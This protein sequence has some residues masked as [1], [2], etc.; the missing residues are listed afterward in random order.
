[1][2][3]SLSLPTRRFKNEAEF[4]TRFGQEIKKLSGFF[5]KI[6]DESR[7]LKPFDSICALDWKVY[8]IEFKFVRSLSCYPFRLLRWSSASKPWA[9]VKWLNDFRNNGWKSIVIVYSA[10]KH[11]YIVVDFA[12]LDLYTHIYF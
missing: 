11:A 3:R 4:T 10:V 7:W 2:V 1:M 8:A 6:S 9:Q 5:H 12:G